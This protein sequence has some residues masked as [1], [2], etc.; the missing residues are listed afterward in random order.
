MVGREGLLYITILWRYPQGMHSKQKVAV[1]DIDG[2]I[3]RSSLLFELVEGLIREKVFPKTARLLYQEQWKKWQDRASDSGYDDFI[4]GVIKAYHKYIKGVRRSEVWKVAD[5]VIEVQKRH[6][7]R[8]TR[9]LVEKLRKDYF[10]LAISH[11]PFEMVTPFAQAMGFDKIYAMVYEVDKEVKFTGNILYEDIILNKDKTLRRA[12]EK[13]N[14]SLKG[15]IGVGDTESDI[16]MLKLVSK[17]IAFNPSSKL[18]NYARKKDWEVVVERKD[19]VYK[20]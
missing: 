1:F 10:M 5:G 4:G 18:H 12:V 9:D 2:T 15:S 17:P 20:M 14:L 7:Y 8:W 3:F 13:E 11:S 16:P 19:V 6:T